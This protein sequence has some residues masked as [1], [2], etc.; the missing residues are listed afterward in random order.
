ML[1][2]VTLPSTAKMKTVIGHLFTLLATAGCSY[3]TQPVCRQEPREVCTE[4]RV[5]H[6][7]IVTE[8]QCSAVPTTRQECTTKQEQQCFFLPETKCFD[9][10]KSI[11]D[12]QQV[13]ECQTITERQCNTL[14]EQ[15]CEILQ[16]RS[17]I[18]VSQ[19]MRSLP[20]DRICYSNYSFRQCS[21][22]LEKECHTEFDTKQECVATTEEQCDTV[23][24]VSCR[25]IT[26]TVS[27]LEYDN[28]CRTE[29]EQQ[30]RTE[31]EDVCNTVNQRECN[32]VTTRSCI[33]APQKECKVGC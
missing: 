29:L 6:T 7:N 24:D 15:Q 9:E 21:T 18:F 25:D 11:K 28:Q 8:R 13:Q 5:P 17:V 26:K 31:F 27:G 20:F 1:S 3:V 33:N 10:P 12:I 14:F 23:P 4:S 16:D 22:S 19:P 30:C 2:V 32:T